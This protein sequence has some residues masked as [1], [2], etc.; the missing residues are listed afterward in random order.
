ME[1][2]AL[3]VQLV[4]GAVRLEQVERLALSVQLVPRAVRLERLALSV[5]L[6]RLALQAR[7]GRQAWPDQVAL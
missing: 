6:V 3:S 2:Q 1:R 7:P 4:P 5:Q